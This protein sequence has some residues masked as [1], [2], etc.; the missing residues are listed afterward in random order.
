M[1][2]EDRPVSGGDGP[3]AGERVLVVNGDDFGRTQ[4]I[5]RGVMRAYEHGILTSA[6]LMVRWP[7][8]SRGAAYCQNQPALSLGLH[9]DLG[10]WAYRGGSWES[11]YQVVEPSDPDAVRAEVRDQLATFRR[12]V[13]RAPTHLDSHQHVHLHE[14]ARSAVLEAAQSLQVPTRACTADV[15]YCGDFYGQTGIGEPW[16]EGITVDALVRVIAELGP[17]TTELSCHPGEGDDFDSVYRVERA[18]EVRVLCDPEVRRA[19]AAANVRLAS[20]ASPAARD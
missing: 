3:E 6:S 16:P 19:L 8:A 7:A 5:N 17:G 12:L 14:P 20:F 4:G 15:R 1:G 2:R 13:G 11:V 9:L 18:Q 10:E